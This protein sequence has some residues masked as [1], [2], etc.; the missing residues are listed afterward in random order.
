MTLSQWLRLYSVKWK[1]DK[2]IMNWKQRGRKWS[3]TN[4]RYYPS[5]WLEGLRKTTKDL[6]NYTWSLGQDL[7]SRP[8]EYK[9][10]VLATRPQCSVTTT[11]MTG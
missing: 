4:L 1:D 3:W 8:P 9:A 7:N 10:A 6:N 5:I 2:W 11:S